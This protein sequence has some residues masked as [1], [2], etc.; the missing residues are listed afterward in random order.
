[1]TKKG[2]ITLGAVAAGVTAFAVG[3]AVPIATKDHSKVW[4]VHVANKDGNRYVLTQLDPKQNKA[5]LTDA[6]KAIWDTEATSMNKDVIA[7]YLG[8][9]DSSQVQ[10]AL[11]KSDKYDSGLGKLIYDLTVNFKKNADK[12]TLVLPNG[13][14]IEFGTDFTSKDL[15]G[16]K[17]ALAAAGT[18][19]AKIVDA[20]TGKFA[21]ASF[22][23]MKAEEK[24]AVNILKAGAVTATVEQDYIDALAKATA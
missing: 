1:M 19:G 4:E 17:T 5:A 7:A 11:S 22:S 6:K 16:R 15:A 3:V 12:F 21:D 10:P 9:T 14:K 23:G 24:F 13:A 20:I 18:Y 8:I 2:W